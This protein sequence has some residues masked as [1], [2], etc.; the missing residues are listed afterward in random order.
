MHEKFTT[1]IL[2]SCFIRSPSLLSKPLIHSEWAVNWDFIGNCYTHKMWHIALWDSL[3]KV[4][5]TPL[6]VLPSIVETFKGTVI[7][8]VTTTT[9]WLGSAVAWPVTVFDRIWSPVLLA[10]CNVAQC[11]QASDSYPFLLKWKQTWISEV[12]VTWPLT[13][14]QQSLKSSSLSPNGCLSYWMIL[15][16]HELDH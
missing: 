2:L 5:P 3:L 12:A 8:V 4:V 6:T 16:H 13:S 14:D 15:R 1:Q 7:Y 11:I 10:T 9:W